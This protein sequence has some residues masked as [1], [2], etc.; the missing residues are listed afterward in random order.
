[1]WQYH[2]VIET[3]TAIAANVVNLDGY[4]VRPSQISIG[5]AIEAV[6]SQ[7]WSDSVL[8]GGCEERESR[9]QREWT[10]MYL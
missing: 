4:E 8:F 6:A 1:M 10:E 9:E 5:A 3:R 2:K 7:P